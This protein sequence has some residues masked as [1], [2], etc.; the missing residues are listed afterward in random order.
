[1]LEKFGML[2]A[3]PMKT[4]PAAYFWHSAELSPQTQEEEQ[5]MPRVPYSTAVENTMYAGVHLS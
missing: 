2:D 5:Y 1:V 4:L 3:K